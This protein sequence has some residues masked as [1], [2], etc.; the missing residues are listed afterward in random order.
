MFQK[1]PLI[2]F[3]MHADGTLF[4]IKINQLRFP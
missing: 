3:L 4:L 1:N 2:A